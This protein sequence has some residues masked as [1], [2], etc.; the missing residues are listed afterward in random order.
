MF[1]FVD[2]SGNWQEIE[3]E[4]NK[5]VIAGLLCKNEKAFNELD[6]DV[7]FFK[8][9][10]GFH[11]NFHAADIKDNL[12]LDEFYMIIEKYIKSDDFRVLAYVIDPKKFYSQTQK[13]SDELYLDTSAELIKELSFGDEN[14]EIEY[15]MKF[16]YAYPQNVLE[17]LHIV[18]EWNSYSQ[19]AKNFNLRYRAFE[20]NKERIKTGILRNSHRIENYQTYIDRLDDI[21]FVKDYLWVEFRLKMEKALIIRERFKERINSLLQKEYADFGL[22]I[23]YR[24]D[25]KYNQKREQSVGVEVIDVINN[26]IWRDRKIDLL[27]YIEI[28]EL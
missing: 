2:E 22:N 17:N 25:I 18:N 14:I 7:K 12:L 3:E 15:D 9:R 19:M 20:K 28:K 23:D 11:G 21:N 10:N 13:D 6:E 4:T 8:I 26:L 16:H 1:Y 24:L 5:L 27:K